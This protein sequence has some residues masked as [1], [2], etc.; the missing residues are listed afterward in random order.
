MK[1]K[2]L[3]GISFLLILIG[4]VVATDVNEL[5][6]PDGW[7]SLH[8]GNYHEVGQSAGQGSGRN[9]MI[10]KYSDSIKSDYCNNVSEDN[11]ITFQNNDKTWNYSDG[12]NQ[13]TGCFE[14]VNIDGEKY[15]VV[16][17][18]QDNV[19]LNKDSHTTYDLMVEFNKLNNFEPVEI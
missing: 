11:Y 16:F 17:S 6:V 4:T 5:K 9:M 10:Q 1:Y 8:N 13:D 2:I 14:V 7:E 12:A 3:I 19:E 15:F 18:T